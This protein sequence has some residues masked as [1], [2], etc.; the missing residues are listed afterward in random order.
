MHKQA[1]PLLRCRGKQLACSRWPVAV[2][3]RPR[4]AVWLPPL[5]LLVPGPMRLLMLRVTGSLRAGLLN[6][7]GEVGIAESQGMLPLDCVTLP[8]VPA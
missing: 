5:L 2:T 1:P 7:D 6:R 3:V 8:L 4:E